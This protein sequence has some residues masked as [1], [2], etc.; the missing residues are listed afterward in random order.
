[1]KKSIFTLI[2]GCLIALM[3]SDSAL[4]QT[5]TP[6]KAGDE[7]DTSGQ[8]IWSAQCVKLGRVPD[9]SGT[10]LARVY[11]G[12]CQPWPTETP[13]PSLPDQELGF[14]TPVANQIVAPL[15]MTTNETCPE[16]NA[17][18]PFGAILV[19]LLIG[20]TIGVGGAVF[21]IRKPR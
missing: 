7:C 1:M 4:A 20:A 11:V 3:V 10:G 18:F 8:C 21:A 9:E 19:S 17:P 2:I 16:T 5:P 13:T 12:F 6:P 14:A 15:G